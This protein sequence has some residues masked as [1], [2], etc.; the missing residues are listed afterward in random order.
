M[1]KRCLIRVLGLLLIVAL[2]FVILPGRP[3]H[4]IWYGNGAEGQ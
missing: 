1:Q 3:L 2:L 4:F